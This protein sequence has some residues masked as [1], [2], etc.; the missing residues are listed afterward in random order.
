ML[1]HSSYNSGTV[2]YDFAVLRSILKLN[3]LNIDFAVP[4]SILNLIILYCDVVEPFCD[5]P[6]ICLLQAL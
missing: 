2:D 3:I 4:R 6:K 5:S 1:E